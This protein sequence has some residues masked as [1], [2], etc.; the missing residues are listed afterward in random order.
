MRSIDMHKLADEV[1][2]LAGVNSRDEEHRV[3]ELKAQGL[4][5]TTWAFAT[6]S[7]LDES[8]FAALARYGHQCVDDF[9]APQLQMALWALS[10]CASL[11][12]TWR[13]FDSAKHT[14]M[15]RNPICCRSLLME[16]EQRALFVHETE[17]WKGLVSSHCDHAIDMAFGEAV[18]VVAA[19]RLASTNSL[20]LHDFPWRTN[21]TPG[22]SFARLACIWCS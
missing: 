19:M 13:L 15:F 3:R 4:S 20:H 17:L 12:K 21:V 16:C 8:L 22:S 18:K 10:R 1:W 7:N 5:N 2:A 6:F 14:G 9:T 11:D